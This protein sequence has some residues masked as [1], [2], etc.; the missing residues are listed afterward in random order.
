APVGETTPTFKSACAAHA[1]NARRISACHWAGVSPDWAMTANSS[2][3]D[4]STFV[5]SGAKLTVRA[6]P[7]AHG[8][9]NWAGTLRASRAST[10]SR[11]RFIVRHPPSGRSGGCGPV[12]CTTEFAGGFRQWSLCRA[13][14]FHHFHAF[15]EPAEF[16]V[17]P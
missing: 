17:P 1:W 11:A 5:P 3:R 12:V 15:E 6:V 10:A 16:L 8:M 2:L 9:P 14:V 7:L 13:E 4:P